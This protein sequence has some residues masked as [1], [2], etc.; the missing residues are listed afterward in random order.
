M[1]RKIIVVNSEKKLKLVST[2]TEVFNCKPGGKYQYRY[3]LRCR[4]NDVIRLLQRLA[5]RSNIV[6]TSSPLL[7]F[8]VTRSVDFIHDF[9]ALLVCS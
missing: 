2:D 6:R 1:L 8:Q 4:E 5:S 7:G 9:G 3:P